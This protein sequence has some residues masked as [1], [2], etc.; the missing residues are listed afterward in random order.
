MEGQRSIKQLNSVYFQSEGTTFHV[1]KIRW[2]R[3]TTLKL[4]QIF[5]EFHLIYVKDSGDR[6]HGKAGGKDAK[7]QKLHKKD[8]SK[9]QQDPVPHKCQT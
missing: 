6:T 4:C 3:H 9:D 5:L 2:S 7:I 1:L 8:T